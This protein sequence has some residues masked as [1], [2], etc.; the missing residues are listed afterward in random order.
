M[1]RRKY[2][3]NFVLVLN[4][5]RHGQH[6][7]GIYTGA[8][9]N[10]VCQGCWL[11]SFNEIASHSLFL[12]RAKFNSSLG[13]ASKSI[14]TKKTLSWGLSKNLQDMFIPTPPPNQGVCTLPVT[15]IWV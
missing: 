14:A 2:I 12:Y 15:L 9:M 6:P 7:V 10:L 1:V 13:D 5:P 4:L 8:K 11:D 3:N